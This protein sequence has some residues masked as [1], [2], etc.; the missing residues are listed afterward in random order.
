MAVGMGLVVQVGEAKDMVKPPKNFP[1][2]NNYKP[3]INANDFR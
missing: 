3:E 2:C 1:K